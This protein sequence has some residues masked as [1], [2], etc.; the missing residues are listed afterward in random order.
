MANLA[1]TAVANVTGFPRR[2][3]VA[4][5]GGGEIHERR[6]RL[7]L[8]NQGSASNTIPKASLGFGELYEVSNAVG[9]GN[10]V[11][12]ASISSDG[13]N[14]LLAAGGSTTATDYAGVYDITVRGRL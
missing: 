5:S 11:I 6:V 12:P 3:Y 13:E 2:R 14:V 7:T 1:A 9:T 10:Q 4:T 8:T